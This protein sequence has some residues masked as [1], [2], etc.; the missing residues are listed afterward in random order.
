MTRKKFA[1]ALPESIERRLGPNTYGRQRIIH[2]DLELLIILHAV[3][4]SDD[5]HVEHAVFWVRPDGEV[6][7]NGR[8]NGARELRLLVQSYEQAFEE[9]EGRYERASSSHA[10]FQIIEELAPITRACKNMSITLQAAREAMRENGLILEMR[11]ATA[12][13]QRGYELLLGDTKVGLEYRIARTAEKQATKAAE[14]VDAQHRLNILAAIF[15]P[16]TAVATIFGMNL[17]HGYEQ[18]ASILFWGVS[19]LGIGLGLWV[20]MWVV[21][22]RGGQKSAA[23]GSGDS[24]G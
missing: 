1:W 15:F 17:Q 5:G 4:R 23:A 20:K 11:D 18:E 24:G 12:E 22:V 6:E 10:L 16:L 21:R 3:P 2:E 8:P 7:F 13:L 9:L 14:A 19:A